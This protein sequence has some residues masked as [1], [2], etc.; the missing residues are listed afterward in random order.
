M[1]LAAAVFLFG[2]ALDPYSFAIG[3]IRT[4]ERPLDECEIT[5]RADD[6]PLVARVTWAP[7][8][9]IEVRVMSAAELEQAGQ[10][11]NL[12]WV[13]NALLRQP[14]QLILTAWGRNAATAYAR[15][16][17]GHPETVEIPLAD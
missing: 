3:D 9:E 4:A 17:K 7:C 11:A 1:S 10:L 15:G 12:G 14:S 5:A 8:R 2:S 6:G 13:R 16:D